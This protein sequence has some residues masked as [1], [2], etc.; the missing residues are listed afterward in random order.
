M[1]QSFHFSRAFLEAASC[2]TLCRSLM[3]I[4]L[5]HG[6]IAAVHCKTCCAAMDLQLNSKQS[7]RHMHP[8]N[9]HTQCFPKI[10]CYSSLGQN[11]MPFTVKIDLIK[12]NFYSVGGHQF[13]LGLCKRQEIYAPGPLVLNVVKFVRWLQR[14]VQR[15]NVQQL[16]GTTSTVKTESERTLSLYAIRSNTTTRPSW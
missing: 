5:G 14:R 11:K 4:G 2:L 15:V 6:Y 10:C 8:K 12:Y 9:Y 3:R 7:Y 1:S 13:S 16:L